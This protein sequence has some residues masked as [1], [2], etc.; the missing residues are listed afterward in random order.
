M[1]RR[2]AVKC[3][4][5]LVRLEL[6]TKPQESKSANACVRR[7]MSAPFDGATGDHPRRRFEGLDVESGQIFDLL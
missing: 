2:A 3:D 4:G 7:A 6:V 5:I 1:Q